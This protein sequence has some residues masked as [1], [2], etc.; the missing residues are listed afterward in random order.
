[1]RFAAGA[2][3]RPPALGEAVERARAPARA[4]RPPHEVDPRP[5]GPRIAVRRS[6]A[7][8]RERR[9]PRRSA[10]PPRVP[11]ALEERRLE[12]ARRLVDAA[13]RRVAPPG[14]RLLGRRMG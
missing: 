7:R 5:R 11:A 1:G 9:R 10:A 6:A 2:A 12:R 13:R 8:A 14:A 4:D 3:R